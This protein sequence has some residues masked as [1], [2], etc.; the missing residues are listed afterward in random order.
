MNGDKAMARTLCERI[1]S[2]ARDGGDNGANNT[3]NPDILICPPFTLL[4]TVDSIIQ[5]SVCQ[6]GAQDMESSANGAF[7]GQISSTMLLDCG[8][9]HVILGHSE[10]RTLCGESDQ[11]V[12]D[13]VGRA[14]AD[15]LIAILCVGETRAE[16]ESGATEQVVQRQVQA[17]IDTVGIQQ[18]K[19]IVVAYEPVWAIGTGLSATPEQARQV[20]QLIR[21]QIARH[22]AG[23]AEGCQILYGGSM[24]PGN[25]G[26]LLSKSDI[27]GGLIG[28]AALIAEDFLGICRA[29]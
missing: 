27:D 11:A 29:A 18:F 14:V 13:K 22:D 21:R 8:C 16:R 20:H 4:S 19:D 28:G 17:V 24:K 3:S 25:A 7:T 1:V 12:A 6:L 9:S 15:G 23:I 5:D 10:R 2:G 26:E